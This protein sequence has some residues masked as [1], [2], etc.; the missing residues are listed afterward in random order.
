MD[1][2]E[3]KLINNTKND[4]PKFE[5]GTTIAQ[6]YAD[7]E[8]N[9]ALLSGELGPN[10][11][12]A[13]AT[14]L[15]NDQMAQ[16]GVKPKQNVF[17]SMIGDTFSKNTLKSTANVGI[18][19]AGNIVG[20]TTKS[21]ISGDNESTVGNVLGDVTNQLGGA[22]SNVNPILGGI[23]NVGGGIISGTINA[24]FG[25]NKKKE[26]EEKLRRARLQREQELANV[27]DKEWSSKINN[28]FMYKYGD[29]DAQQSL[30]AAKDGVYNFN[31][32]LNKFTKEDHVINTSYGLYKGKANAKVSRGEIIASKDGSLYK[33]PFGKN[34]SAYALLN[35][36]DSVYS[37]KIRD[38]FTGLKMADV[39]P[40]Y[41][42]QGRKDLADFAQDLGRDMKHRKYN[43]K[44]GK[45]DEGTKYNYITGNL[46]STIGNLWGARQQY[47]EAS[48]PLRY[49]N[50]YAPNE[51]FGKA[52]SVL[53]GLGIDYYPVVAQNKNI[54]SAMKYNIRRSGG[55]STG[56]KMLLNRQ[57]TYDTERNNADV[58]FKRALQNN[59]YR[60]LAAQERMRAGQDAA[61]MK[62][63]ANMF[64]EDM[65]AK[66]HNAAVQGKQMS[67]F[68][69]MNA[70]Q[71]FYANEFKR[72]QFN[73]AMNL[74]E[75]EQRDNA[76]DRKAK[77]NNIKNIYVP[78][79]QSFYKNAIGD[80]SRS[81]FN[82]TLPTLDEIN[83]IN[84]GI[85][86]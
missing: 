10:P 75:Q 33:V 70:I 8:Y 73:R 14:A 9:E 30:Y 38:P 27:R 1:L 76:A 18:G 19:V 50:V 49:P 3:R 62:M 44:I 69:T 23:V 4:L 45:F 61:K 13:G 85:R 39:A 5:L 59:Q 12:K 74:Y 46:L 37:T 77:A 64:D 22:L 57:L 16:T 80:F 82:P 53:D 58:F 48:E 15:F 56:Q 51:Q 63:Q 32:V 60:Q 17:K 7:D 68:N 29:L 86:R 55:L 67:L 65:L 52:Q 40:L 66:A 42:A 11:N 6:E 83:S 78:K 35:D 72:H 71:Q 81:L 79:L 28:D 43:N 20:N 41:V 36:E 84:Y 47:K 24:L 34:D 21:L 31:N 54:E 26:Q 25:R 2:K